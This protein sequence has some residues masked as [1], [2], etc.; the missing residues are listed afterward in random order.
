M[1]SGYL[2]SWIWDTVYRFGCL[3][4]RTV[5]LSPFLSISKNIYP[6]PHQTIMGVV[7][8][9]QWM[10]STNFLLAC[11][12]TPCHTSTAVNR[13]SCCCWNDGVGASNSF[14][15]HLTPCVHFFIG[16]RLTE[17][18]LSHICLDQRAT[19]QLLVWVLMQKILCPQMSRFASWHVCFGI[20]QRFLQASFLCCSKMVEIY[21][22]SQYSE[23]NK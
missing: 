4:E 12:S 14:L 21:Q 5:Q 16:R 6:H 1:K 13:V 8:I 7:D 19:R 10:F 22:T 11:Y 2:L 20:H 15:I 18:H 17:L 3:H 9:C 23:Y